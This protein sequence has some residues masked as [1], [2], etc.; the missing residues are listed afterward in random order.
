MVGCLLDHTQIGTTQC[1]DCQIDA[2]LRARV[3]AMG[4]TLNPWLRVVG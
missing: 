3:N 2:P 4:E 1:E